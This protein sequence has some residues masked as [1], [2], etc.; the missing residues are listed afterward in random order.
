[1]EAGTSLIY[2]LIPLCLVLFFRLK[3][4]QHELKQEKFMNNNL[5]EQMKRLINAQNIE[6]KKEEE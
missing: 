4:E 2:C 5:R 6:A 3:L 1:V